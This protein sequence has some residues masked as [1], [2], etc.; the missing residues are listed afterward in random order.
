MRY[1]ANV[2]TTGRQSADESTVQ[3]TWTRAD[4]RV[5][6][7]AGMRRSIAGTAV[8]N[9]TEWYDFG[10][11]SFVIPMITAQ[12]FEPMGWGNVAAFAGLGVSFVFRPLGGFFWGFLGDRIGRKN[13]LAATILVMASGTVGVGLLPGFDA[14]GYMAPALLLIARAVQGFSTGGEYVGAITFLTE[15]APDKTRGHY[16]SFVPIG[17]LSGYVTGALFVVLLETS[18][19]HDVM[20]SLGWRAP[21]LLAGPLAVFGLIIRLRLE[22]SPVYEQ[23]KELDEE[24]E[25]QQSTEQQDNGEESKADTGKSQ[26]RETVIEQWRPMLVCGG[27][28]IAFN[29]TNYMLTGYMPTY[30]RDFSGLSNI[31]SIIIVVIVMLVPIFLVR[32]FGKLSDRVGRKPVMAGACIAIAVIAF[33]MF[34]LIL[35]GNYYAGFFGVLPMGLVLAAFMGAEPSTLPAL[36]PTHVRYGATSV[37]YNIAVSAFGGM[38]PLVTSVLVSEDEGLFIPAYMLIAAGLIGLVAVWRTPETAGKRLPGSTGPVVTSEEEARELA[39]DSQGK[40]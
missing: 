12:F 3:T 40:R 28:V 15:H 25:E 34:M 32:R 17:T 4:I 6:D 39:S 7:P 19:P 31:V 23:Q 16:L 10:V 24:E 8:G 13:T 14:L 38:T 35:M 33:P 2:A 37:S 30:M 5:S 18:L 22:E 9:F 29:V 21:F 20:Y 36:F 1:G 11:Y 26:F 27:L